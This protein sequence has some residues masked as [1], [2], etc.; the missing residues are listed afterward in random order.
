MPGSSYVLDTCIEQA[1]LVL[2]NLADIVNLLNTLWA[3]LDLGGEE[4]ALK[5]VSK[6]LLHAANLTP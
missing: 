5:L 6:V 2:V 3:E 4:V 1:L